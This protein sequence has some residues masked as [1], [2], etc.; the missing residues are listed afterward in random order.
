MDSSLAIP[1]MRPTL[2]SQLR[3]LLPLY[4]TGL[5]VTLC[6]IGAVNAT[7][8]EGALATATVSL[9]I[10]GFAV[11]LALRLA[12]VDPNHA[13]YPALGI[14][15]FV[16]SQRYVS[17]GSF[18]EAIGGPSQGTWQPDI[19]LATF[20]AWLVVLL[21][22]TLLT[23]S[24]VLF[25]PVPAIALLGLT[26]SSNVNTEIAVY[27]F[28]FL[29]ATL[30]LT[31]YEHYLRLQEAARRE[32]EPILRA[33]ATTAALLFV[34]V[35]ATGGA[36]TLVG[37]P[38]LARLSP[39]TGAMVRKAQ[40]SIPGFSPNVQNSS[41]FV[42]V[43]AGPIDL[44]ETPVMDVYAPGPGLWRTRVYSYYNGRGWAAQPNEIR[45]SVV[46]QEETKIPRPP[47]L[48]PNE[49]FEPNGYS[50]PLKSDPQR[51][52]SA[53]TRQMKQLIYVRTS[54]PTWLPAMA[55]PIHLRY[56]GETVVV[57]PDS[58][59][60][61]GRM[62][63]MAGF[64]YEVTSEVTEGRPPD[65]RA[66]P[67]ADPR[68]VDPQYL[69]LP[70]SATRVKALAQRITAKE[71]NAYDKAMAI[72]RY[73][74]ENCPYSLNAEATPR[75]EDAVDY[76]LF[77]T[78]EGAC[79]LIGSAMTLMCRAVGIPARVATGYATGSFDRDLGAYTVK[80]SDAHLWVE[81][82]FPHYGWLTFNPAPTPREE[83]QQERHTRVATRARR[84][85]RGLSRAGLASSLSMLLLL[86]VGATAA[87]SG[88]DLLR[89]ELRVRQRHR[90]ML[91]SGDGPA[92]MS[93]VYGRMTALLG[94][95]GWARRPA[96]TPHEYLEEV[97]PHLAGPLAPA[98]PF[99]EAITCR[100]VAARYSRATLSPAELEEARATLAE[101]QRLL[102]QQAR[103]ARRS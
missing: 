81:L 12:R 94:R 75:G 98:A 17:S 15:L 37:R 13:L 1:P 49:D 51:D 29:F 47:G 26:G 85:W 73:L 35:M 86:I 45:E 64:V 99:V 83:Q 59:V 23:N 21:S 61:V 18:M 50:L 2:G 36:L 84:I 67:P 46:S 33:H 96:S 91:R 92:V 53:P 78:R 56:P 6:G 41:N 62:Y 103:H 31:G 54:L 90:Q 44:S 71:Q 3:T 8:E 32:P 22:F 97:L 82:F 38:V 100:F 5:V 48:G 65:L 34:L 63:L 70:T 42:P 10:L 25:T 74:E 79:D 24:L 7:V 40:Q 28:V 39:F 77:T 57:E 19:A 66:L 43:G 88:T 11:S 95:A 4:L 60:L 93:W 20:L 89:Q 68:A 87:K 76:Y 80:G 16:V 101:L 69:E 58:G 72:Q 30:F 27:F 102:R 55:R 9:T 52:R 14:G